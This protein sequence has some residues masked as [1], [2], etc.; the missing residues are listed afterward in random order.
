MSERSSAAT[1][2]IGLDGFV[3]LAETIEDDELWLLVE[4]TASTAWC[5]DLSA[6]SARWGTA[7]A[8]SR[9]VA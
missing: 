4:T 5:S 1:T 3:V 7:V 9:S 2:L 8:V 6:V